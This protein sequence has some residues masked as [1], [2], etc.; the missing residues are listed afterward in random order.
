MHA[1]GKVLVHDGHTDSQ[2]RCERLKG[3]D[4]QRQIHKSKYDLEQPFAD[5]NTDYRYRKSITLM[6]IPFPCQSTQ[7]FI[8]KVENQKSL[9]FVPLY[10]LIIIS[11]PCRH[12][13]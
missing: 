3:T 2:Y 4:Q 8:E 9:V 7:L 13:W 6:F 12:T 10:L 1:Y 5:R 11:C